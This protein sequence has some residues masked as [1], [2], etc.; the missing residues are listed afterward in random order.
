MSANLESLPEPASAPDPA[1]Q[2]QPGPEPGAPSARSV[3]PGRLRTVLV[4]GSGLIG[5]SIALAL[6]EE[7]IDVVLEDTSAGRLA[8]A[9]DLGAGRPRDLDDR[10]ELA[11]VA[12]PPAAVPMEVMRLQRLNL[13]RSYTDVASSKAQPVSELEAMGA[14]MSSYLGSHPVAGREH[15]GPAAAHADL[16]IGRP[17]VLTPVA[18]SGDEAVADV[19]ALIEA[20]G[21][22]PFVMSPDDH[23]A[24]LATVSHLPHLVASVL[25][26]QLA[27]RPESVLGLAGTGLADTTRIPSCGPRSW[28]PMPRTSPTLSLASLGT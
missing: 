3:Q 23:D 14:D 19:R 15:S 26:A 11:I 1:R 13:S 10:F 5:T 20:C 4:V 12:V 17:W 2:S 6:R 18:A 21:A 9:V 8:L 27:E 28:W 25:A 16:F 22:N 24:A 7:G